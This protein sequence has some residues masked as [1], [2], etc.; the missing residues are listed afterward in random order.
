[1]Q[2]LINKI[3]NCQICSAHLEHGVNPVFAFSSKSKIAIIGQAP[4]IKVHNSG[5]PWQDKSGDRLREWLGVTEEQFYNS[6]NFAIVPMGFCYPGKGKSGD[7]PPRKE[8]APE[9]HAKIFDVCNQI[10]LTLLIGSY[11]QQ[12]YLKEKAKKH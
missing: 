5:V 8:C 11:A 6:D 3:L 1:M 2:Q 9:W 10:D 12:Y 7:L 4:G